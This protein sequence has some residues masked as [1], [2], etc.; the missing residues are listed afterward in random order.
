MKNHLYTLRTFLLSLIAL[1]S[2]YVLI[3]GL[4]VRSNENRLNVRILTNSPLDSFR[5][6]KFDLAKKKKGKNY[7]EATV[8]QNELQQIKKSGFKVAMVST[9]GRNTSI[10]PFYKTLEEIESDLH[11]LQLK[12]P[13]I[14][15]VEKIGESTALKLPIWAAKISDNA[16]E[17]EDEPRILFM[18]VHHAREPIGANICLRIMESLCEGY[19]TDNKI[20]EWVDDLEIWLVPVVNPDGYKYVM[21]NNLH[22]PWWRKNLRDNDGD[23]LF[24]P[25]Y[26]GVD[27]NRNYDY[28]WDEGGD[29][30]PNSWFYRGRSPFSEN[31]TKS[32][33]RLALRENFVIGISY[34]SYG[35]SILFP[36]G[37]YNRPPDLE[38]IVEIASE[39]A[40]R[41]RKES[42]R[43]RYSI[44]PLNGRVGQSSIW[45][46]GQLRVLDYIVEVGTEYFPAEEHIDFILDEH[47]KG[48]YYLFDKM[49]NT[50]VSGHVYDGETGAPLLAEVEVRELATDYVQP[51]RTDPRFG[52]FHR[53][54]NPGY[55]TFEIRSE[56]YHPKI[57]SDVRVR[58]GRFKELNVGLRR[59]NKVLSNGASN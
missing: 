22:F 11:R 43:G 27:L 3:V 2:G 35:E 54:L 12:Y 40:A 55:Y 23:G 6:K 51:R 25:L 47:L 56:G 52:S 28:N 7:V 46:Y 5:L 15:A 33:L 50:G 38:L 17:S 19:D 42:G 9:R 30:K 10:P 8:S 31:E 14:L 57:V 53:L 44:L 21:D 16:A 41:I 37:N 32:I 13:N 49:L 45:M 34:H 39:M 1:L 18:G 36:W 58:R 26:D 48:A 4:S 29:G 59:K 24:N 20:E